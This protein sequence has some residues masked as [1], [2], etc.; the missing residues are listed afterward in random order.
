MN[1]KIRSAAEDPRA[2]AEQQNNSYLAVLSKIRNITGI[3]SLDE[4][5]NREHRDMVKKAVSALNAD[6]FTIRQLRFAALFFIGEKKDIHD[7]K[8]ALNMILR[9]LSKKE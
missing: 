5:K 8:Q 6:D 2:T 1:R 7:G 9:E 4:M 3:C